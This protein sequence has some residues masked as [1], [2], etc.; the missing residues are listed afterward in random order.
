MLPPGH[1]HID[2][3]QMFSTFSIFLDRHSVEYPE[4]LPEK[5]DAAYKK[6]DTKPTGKFL[7]AVFNFI[8]FFAPFLRDIGGL[9]SAHVFLFR[10]LP[11]GIVGMKVKQWHSTDC[12]WTGAS[13]SPQEWIELM[14]EIPAG[15]PEVVLPHDI[16]DMLT[17][18][19]VKKY[20]P[21]LNSANFLK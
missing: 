6:E 12:Q 8:G 17:D 3:D 4:D 15:F 5:L 11:S 18:K 19:V 14:H 10:K 13:N 16:E 2:V 1:T 20:Q 7:P 21:W 9:N